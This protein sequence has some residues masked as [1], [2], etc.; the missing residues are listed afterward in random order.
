MN[1]LVAGAAVAIMIAIVR[2]TGVICAR[3]ILGSS[4]GCKHL[5][6]AAAV[7]GMVAIVG[8][9]GMIRAGAILG[10]NRGVR[11]RTTVAAP[12]VGATLAVVAAVNASEDQAGAITV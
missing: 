6:A 2:G 3:A 7:A 12:T 1:V 4:R 8:G 5:V 9:T 11:H 10:P